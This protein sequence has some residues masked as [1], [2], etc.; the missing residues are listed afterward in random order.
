MYYVVMAYIV[1]ASIVMACIVMA[2]VI[3]ACIVMAQGFASVRVRGDGALHG[4]DA[5][6]VCR[7]GPRPPQVIGHKL[8]RP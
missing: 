8:Y 2:Y 7:P 3:L 6:Q 4:G 5:D 1:L